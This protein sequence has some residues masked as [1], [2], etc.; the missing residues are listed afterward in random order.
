MRTGQ[1]ED[2][3]ST[4]PR[5]IRRAAEV[6]AAAANS[7]ARNARDLSGMLLRVCVVAKCGYLCRTLRPD[8]AA[9]AL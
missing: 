8:L 4:N 2:A 6:C 9:P 5:S 7:E 3:A 1:V